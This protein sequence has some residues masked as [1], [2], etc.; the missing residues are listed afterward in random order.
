MAEP[1]YHPPLI[2][3][4]GCNFSPVNSP[5]LFII[6][7]L[8]SSYLIGF[9]THISLRILFVIPWLY[10]YY[11][12]FHVVISQYKNNLFFCPIIEF[13]FFYFLS[14]FY[15]VRYRCMVWKCFLPFYGLLF[16]FLVVSLV[17]KRKLWSFLICLFFFCCLV[18]LYCT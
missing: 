4:E 5:T 14:F 6:C 7:L 3:D 11:T 12:Y 15:F 2:K 16:V 10:L 8:D 13:L 9:K 17:V 18:F 1:F